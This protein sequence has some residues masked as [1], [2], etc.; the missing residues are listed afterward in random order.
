M[1]PGRSA[2]A[3]TFKKG[4]AIAA[5]AAFATLLVCGSLATAQPDPRPDPARG[6]VL[7]KKWCAACHFVSKDQKVGSPDA[8]TFAS[9]GRRA[10]LSAEWLA[11]FLLSPHPL[12]P[13]M[14]LSRRE[15]A[16]LVAHIRAQA[17]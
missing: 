8:P 7:A 5:G 6:E 3:R 9:I 14:S 16:D 10:Q 4:R 2:A 15:V 17:D 13:D 11:L 1:N 12:M